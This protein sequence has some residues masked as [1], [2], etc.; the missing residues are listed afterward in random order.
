MAK[1]SFQVGIW[2]YKPGIKREVLSH[3]PADGLRALV[4][5]EIIHCMSGERKKQ[6][7][8]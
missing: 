5:D 4:T 8:C 3:K 1:Q 6:K 2:I 7:C